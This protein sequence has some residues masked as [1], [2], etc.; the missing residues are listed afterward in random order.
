M[1]L[2]HNCVI[3]NDS[4]VYD[5]T[6]HHT[7]SRRDPPSPEN[8]PDPSVPIIKQ[9][10]DTRDNVPPTTNAPLAPPPRP[11]QNS[12]GDYF[13]AQIHKSHLS[14]EPNPFENAFGNP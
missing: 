9:P 6:D 13:G 11:T 2:Q 1:S 8:K 14:K 10:E 7:D 3:V 5:V 12:D 4:G